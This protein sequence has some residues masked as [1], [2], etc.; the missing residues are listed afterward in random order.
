MIRA[1][2]VLAAAAIG[3]GGDTGGQACTEIGCTD[4]LGIG[5]SFTEPGAYAFQIVA[6]GA[7]ITCSATLPL[8]PCEQAGATCSSPQAVLSASGCALPESQHSLEGL[9]LDGQHPAS[10]EVVVE[11]DGAELVRRTFTPQYQR[12]APNGEACGPICHQASVQLA[13]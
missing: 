4:G 13:P 2:V 8:P 6:D 12:V 7:T 9:M 1:A 5:F 3:C 10:V 11:R